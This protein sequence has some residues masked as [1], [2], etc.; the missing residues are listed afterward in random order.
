MKRMLLVAVLTAGVCASAQELSGDFGGYS[1]MQID[2]GRFLGS[3]DGPMVI[4][5]MTDGVRIVLLSDDPDV[6][7]LPIRAYTMQFDYK[8]QSATPSRIIMEGNVEVQHPQGSVTAERADWDFD[9][10][11]LVF[12]GNPVMNSETIRGLRGSRIIIN[13]KTNTLEVVDMQA[14]QV[15]LRGV[16]DTDP[17]LLTEADFP[18][19]PGFVKALKAQV[20]SDDPSPGRQ[21]LA[22]L[23]A[24]V[25]GQ[26]SS[27]PLEVLIERKSSL[28]NQLNKAIKKPGLYNEAAWKKIT[29]SNEIKELM[30]KTA[31]EAAEQT[32]LNRL[33]LEAAY[34]EYIMKR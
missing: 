20:A 11:Q 13:F 24:D 6:K 2:A 16:G 17:S 9:K 23:G 5:E 7:P 33:L 29:L 14:Q 10:E 22:H 1:A 26:L 34:P 15:P 28:I 8:A 25:S 3:F 21:I 31:P 4:K 12:T 18:D 27:T 32:R 19:W 30:A